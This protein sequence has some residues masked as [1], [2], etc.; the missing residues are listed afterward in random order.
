[1]TAAAPFGRLSYSGTRE[2]AN[3]ESVNVTA[4]QHVDGIDFHVAELAR[5][6]ELRGRL[7]FGNGAALADQSVEFTGNDLRYR[8]H[9]RTD[10]EGGFV[11]RVLAGRP[12]SLIGKIRVSRNEIGKCPQFE[13]NPRPDA[14]P[15]ILTST[16]YPVA[17][18]K[19]LSEIQVLFPFPSCDAWLRQ[20]AKRKKP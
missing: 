18:D 20:E 11:V 15:V 17:G 7:T 16:P 3:A 5:R 13:V 14:Y 1:M 10:A 2:V 12:G 4:G 19:S 8:E 9:G 6:I